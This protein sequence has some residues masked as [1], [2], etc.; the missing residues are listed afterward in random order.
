MYFPRVLE[1]MAK[2]GVSTMTEKEKMLAGEMY[3]AADPQ[4]V[5]ERNRARQL[6]HSYNQTL[7]EE[8]ARRTEI[9]TELLGDTKE[10]PTIEPSIRVDYGYNIHTGTA[11]FAN[12]DC[13]FLDVCEIRFGD[14]CMLGPGV[15][16]YTATH[17]LDPVERSSGREYAIPVKIGDDVWIGG[18]ALIMP[19]VTVGDRVVIASGSVVTKDIPNDAVVGGNPARILKNLVEESAQ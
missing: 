18:G 14:R 4:L 9:L 2:R 15:H 3:L 12:F 13:V 5:A 19:G 8:T 10:P 17:P 1:I 11:F 16:I 7:P 6:V